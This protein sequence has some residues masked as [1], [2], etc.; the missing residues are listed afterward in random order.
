LPSF[1]GTGSTG[2]RWG[3]VSSATAVYHRVARANNSIER[4]ISGS[5]AWEGGFCHAPLFFLSCGS[6]ALGY[7][8]PIRAL[9]HPGIPDEPKEFIDGPI[10]RPRREAL[11]E[12]GRRKQGAAPRQRCSLGRG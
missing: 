10:R 9:L 7:I 11:V 3:R 6:A 5:G 4:N 12:H 2:Q 1:S 8:N